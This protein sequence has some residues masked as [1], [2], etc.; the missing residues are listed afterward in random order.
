M[1][2]LSHIIKEKIYENL[3]GEDLMN[4][5]IAFGEDMDLR[6]Y[7]DNK[8]PYSRL[9]VKMIGYMYDNFCSSRLLYYLDTAE[10]L[11]YDILKGPQLSM[12]FLSEFTDKFDNGYWEYVSKYQSLSEEFMKCN[13]RK[14][15]WMKILTS[16]KLSCEFILSIIE[17]LNGYKNVIIEN[18]KLC[19]VCIEKMC[20]RYNKSIMRD[21][22]QYQKLSESF[23]EKNMY[24]VSLRDVLRYQKLSEEFLAR[25]E[26]NFEKEDWMLISMYQ[27]LSE[28]F[29][30]EYKTKLNMEKIIQIQKVSRNFLDVHSKL[31]DWE[32]ISCDSELSFSIVCRMSA[33]VNWS[34]IWAYNKHLSELIDCYPREVSLHFWIFYRFL[35]SYH[36]S[37]PNVP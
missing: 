10:S 35:L 14:L 32:S 21:V 37:F 18:Q 29:I 26:L 30:I 7:M 36:T 24:R 33:Y 23:I 13:F 3:D 17:K 11:W 15:N 25:N 34:K 5:H 1:L 22:C 8:F 31:I 16:H 27:E 2:E 20:N 9:S 28:K 19:E 12:S 6:F 4:L